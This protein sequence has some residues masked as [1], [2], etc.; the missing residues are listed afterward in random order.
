[1]PTNYRMPK[2]PDRTLADALARIR[3]VFN[4]EIDFRVFVTVPHQGEVDISDDNPK[5]LESLSF[6]FDANS[7]TAPSFFLRTTAGNALSV[8]RRTEEITDVVQIPD[9]WANHFKN[10]LKEKFPPLYVRFIGAVLSELRISDTEAGLRGIQDSQW[11]RYRNAQLAV[12]NSLEQ[13]AQSLIIKTSERNAQ[14]DQQ[15]AE[16]FEK[17]E[18]NLREELQKTRAE[19]QKE[20]ESKREELAAQEKALADKLSGFETKESQYVTRQKQE[21]QIKQVQA[22]LEGWNLTKGTTS[23]RSPIMW[24]YFVGIVSSGWFAFYSIHH[25]YDILKSADDIAKLLWWQWL[26]L[27]LKALFPLAMFTTFL[28]YFIRWASTWA[29]QHAEEEFRNRSLLIDIGRSGW[30]IE[31]VRDAQERS[32]EFPTA[33]LTELSRNLFSFSANP[34]GD[35]HPQAISDLLTQGL[36][37]I[38]VKS[39]DGSEL[40][41]SRGKK[42]K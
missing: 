34:D 20:F 41:A 35:I 22:W 8:N 30:L 3:T 25:S 37:S 9:D 32:A 26:A 1:M 12:I 23:K 5:R 15:R 18:A 39:P 36:S 27:T 31:A 33:L 42:P 6:L 40:E 16:R 4:G 14:L 24:A 13:S 11:N 2:F 38:R 19:L 17:L 7:E 29:R 10:Q 28:I 21:Q